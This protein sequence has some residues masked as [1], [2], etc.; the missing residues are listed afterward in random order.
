METLARAERWCQAYCG[1]PKD[2]LYPTCRC[3]AEC[4]A[5]LATDEELNNGMC[6]Y[7]LYGGCWACGGGCDGQN[8]RSPWAAEATAGSLPSSSGLE[9]VDPLVL[10]DP[11]GRPVRTTKGKKPF[12]ELRQDCL[13]RQLI[14][15]PPNEVQAAIEDS[16]LSSDRSLTDDPDSDPGSDPGSAMVTD[17]NTEEYSEEADGSFAAESISA[18]ESISSDADEDSFDWRACL[19]ERGWDAE[20]VRCWLEEQEAIKAA[21]DR[22][23]RVL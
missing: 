16:D 20:R 18:T 11:N 13:D 12:D 4:W 3:V 23:R 22:R 6:N 15:V 1:E 7:C 19:L 21:V 5:Y 10:L 17:G 8:C 14:G 2:R 9:P